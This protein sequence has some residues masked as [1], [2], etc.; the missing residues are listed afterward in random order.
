MTDEK[1]PAEPAAQD[2]VNVTTRP[3]GF[4]SAWDMEDALL[5]RLQI[6]LNVRDVVSSRMRGMDDEQL[7]RVITAAGLLYWE[8]GESTTMLECLYAA[9]EYERNQ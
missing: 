8:T 3:Y 2:R 6:P 9:V 1:Q 4:R 7:E 5:G